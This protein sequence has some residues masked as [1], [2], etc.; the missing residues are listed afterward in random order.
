MNPQ[1]EEN[2]LRRYFMINLHESMGTGLDQ[3]A[4]PESAV[5]LITDCATQTGARKHLLWPVG[6]GLISSTEHE[7]STAHKN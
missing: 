2:G 1:K 4:S 5:R 6:K 3:L 7:I